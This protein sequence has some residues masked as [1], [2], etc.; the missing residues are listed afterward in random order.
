MSRGVTLN[1]HQ[2]KEIAISIK[3]IPSEKVLNSLE[4]EF[5]A[6]EK[7]L[8]LLKKVD[9]K[10]I[11]ALSHINENETFYLREDDSDTSELLTQ[12]QIF[13]NAKDFY[14]D[15]VVVSKVVK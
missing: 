3:L 8:V 9:I 15:Y 7:T 10:N 11:K 1:K 13:E 14:Q 5:N 6:I 4:R 2:F 12:D